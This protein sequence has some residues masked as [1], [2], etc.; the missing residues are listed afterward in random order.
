MIPQWKR[1]CYRGHDR[2]SARVNLGR[3][4]VSVDFRTSTCPVNLR[5]VFSSRVYCLRSERP[6]STSCESARYS[7]RI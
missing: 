2:S 3:N 1:L 7:K 4:R 6:E 5:L